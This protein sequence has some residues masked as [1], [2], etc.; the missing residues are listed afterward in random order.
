MLTEKGE[1][2]GMAEYAEARSELPR[3]LPAS[4]GPSH[5]QTVPAFGSRQRSC[6][7]SEHARLLAHVQPRR[8][9]QSMMG[10]RSSPAAYIGSGC[11]RGAL[12]AGRNGAAG[13]A[14]RAG[15]SAG[16]HPAAPVPADSPCTRILSALGGKGS[17]MLALLGWGL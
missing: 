12:A 13:E 10:L 15:G 7:V 8:R 17:G 9:L 1:N 11:G 16:R 5:L 14:V 6:N 3:V 2:T 4:S